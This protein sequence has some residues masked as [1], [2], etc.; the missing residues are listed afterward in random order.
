MNP[1]G[2]Q[3]KKHLY[4]FGPFRLDPVK[5]ILAKDGKRIALAAKA[6]D[7]LVVL[8]QHSDQILT[9]DQLM[10]LVWPDSFVEENNLNQQISRLRRA[11]GEVDNGETYIETVPR[12]GYRFVERVTVLPGEEPD[13]LVTRR[14]STHVLIHKEEEEQITAWGGRGVE[15]LA[16]RP[17]ANTP[18]PATSSSVAPVR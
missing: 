6:F 4:G 1:P 12:Q 18:A 3:E 14:T 2:G 10:K 11:L 9:K 8:V 13:L 15:D 7:T 17:A 16:S 5:R